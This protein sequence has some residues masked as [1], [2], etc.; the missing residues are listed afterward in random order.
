MSFYARKN[1]GLYFALLTKGMH[2]L[3]VETAMLHFAD[4]VVDF[5]V[6]ERA[7]DSER[8]IIIKKMRGTLIS[9]RSLPFVI[10]ERGITI[11]TAGRIT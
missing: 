8:K 10:E 2:N 3:Q 7:H 9:L 11:E 4:G 6:S 5:I 1:K